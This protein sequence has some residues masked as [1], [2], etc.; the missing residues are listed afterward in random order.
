MS[1][2]PRDVYFADCERPAGTATPERTCGCGKPLGKGAAKYCSQACYVAARAASIVDRFWSKVDKTPGCWLWTGAGIGWKNQRR[3]G[4]FAV[5]V[6]GKTVPQYAHR[7][8]WELANG[9]PVPEGQQVCH[10]CDVPRCV[11]PD[12]LF[13]GDRY[14]N[15]QDAARKGRLHVARPNKQTVP[16]DRLP[17]VEAL[18]AAGDLTYEQIGE[19]FGVSKTWVSLYANGKRRQ[20]DRPRLKSNKG[21]A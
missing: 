11:R 4:A 1:H 6:E 9:R 16:K 21:A 7:V 13:L 18:L 12:H 8:S 15:M 19:R 20:Y 14:A 2:N 3:Y 5:T 10:T 17:E